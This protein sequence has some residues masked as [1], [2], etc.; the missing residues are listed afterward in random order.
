MNLYE[1]DSAISELIDSETGEI[2]DFDA[3]EKLTM[4]R[5][6]KIENVALWI[7]NLNADKKAYAAEKNAFA[8]REKHAAKLID[9]LTKWLAN[10]CDGK[11]F[12]TTK[13]AVTFR[14]STAVELS[15]CPN[16]P[17]EYI[18]VKQECTPDKVALKKAMLEGAEFEG[19][20]LI[21]R[22]NATVK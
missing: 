15:E 16:I 20:K 10:A 7:K 13:C 11:N 1:I 12:S 8:E 6:A 4:E 14:E 19:V 18:R 2:E 5:D 22:L 3:L 17:A 21:K 9:S